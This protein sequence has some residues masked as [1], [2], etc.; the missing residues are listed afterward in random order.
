MGDESFAPSC[1]SRDTSGRQVP[2]TL[3][4][5]VAQPP[6]DI[7]SKLEVSRDVVCG[8]FLQRLVPAVGRR[9]GRRDGL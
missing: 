4:A 9:Y 5:D 2:T 8:S 3:G 1:P 7:N 6:S